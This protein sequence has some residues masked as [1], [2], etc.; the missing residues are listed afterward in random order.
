M[1]GIG[2]D[3]PDRLPNTGAS[4]QQSRVSSS[5]EGRRSEWQAW[6]ATRRPSIVGRTVVID[7]GNPKVHCEARDV[8]EVLGAAP[9]HRRWGAAGLRHPGATPLPRPCKT[10]ARA[11]VQSRGPPSPKPSPRGEK[12]FC[13]PYP[14]AQ[15]RPTKTDQL[16]RAPGHKGGRLMDAESF[17]RTVGKDRSFS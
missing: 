8:T 14:I 4:A 7:E 6:T 10:G 5:E 9:V 2:Y 13:K 15:K 3:S 16:R 17:R 11:T 12:G 1:G